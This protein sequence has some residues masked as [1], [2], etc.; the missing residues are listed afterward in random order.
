[1]LSSFLMNK[2]LLEYLSL[3]LVLHVK[4]FKVWHKKIYKKGKVISYI[5]I[6]P[7]VFW[8]Y[9]QW[10]SVIWCIS[11]KI[12]KNYFLKNWYFFACFKLG[13]FRCLII[14]FCNDWINISSP[15]IIYLSSKIKFP[16]LTILN[17][18]DIDFPFQKKC[19]YISYFF[20][21]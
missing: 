5:L 19:I 20:C 15:I 10:L 16:F 17:L 12:I 6:F 7:F 21:Y 3:Y 18:I 11:F 9:P 1:M 8:V 2:A 4:S 13:L 14:G